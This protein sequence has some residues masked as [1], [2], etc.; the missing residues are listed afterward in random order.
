MESM[1]A[2]RITAE[3]VLRAGSPW[4][5]C[6]IWDGA[7]IVREPSGGRAELVGTRVVGPLF[8]HVREC[9]LGWTW[10]SSQGFLLARDPDRL[11][12]ADGAF[13]SKDRLADV[14][15]DGFIEL[16]PDFLIEVRSP[17]DTWEAVIEKCG[18]W[19]AHGAACVWAIDPPTRTVAVFRQ[20]LV[21]QIVR[22]GGRVDAAPALPA[23]A[24]DVATLFEGLRYS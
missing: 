10:G 21:P 11:L 16:S 6:E 7:P 22:R 4:R 13:V 15:A 18:I 20:D 23:F 5:D 8:A 2:T 14:P 19:I 3:D 12:A 24:L 9:G 17:R 1:P